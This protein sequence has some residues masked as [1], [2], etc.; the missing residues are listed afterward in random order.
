MESHDRRLSDIIQTHSRRVNQ[1]VENVLQLSRRHR[2]QPKKISLQEWLTRFVQHY[3]QSHVG[4]IQIDIHC[5]DPDIVVNIDASQME[6]VM[7]NLCDNGLR[8]SAHATGKAHV[9]LQGYLD[10]SLATP[11]LDIVDD[12]AGISTENSSRIFEPFFTTE[13]QGTGL[14]LYIAREIC[15]ANQAQLTY[16]RNAKGKSCFQISFSHPDKSLANPDLYLM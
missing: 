12:G 14:G 5:D 11:C 3:H 2:P 7:T 9:L 10:P 1:I 8:H 16:K 15:E 4:D 13:S 6:Q